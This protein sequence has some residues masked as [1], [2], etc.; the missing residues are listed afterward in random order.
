VVAAC[1]GD[2]AF[3]AAASA[4]TVP[5]YNEYLRA[6]PTGAH[7]R[8]ARARVDLLI[9]SADW[10]RAREVG[11]AES[12]QQYLARHSS[13]VHTQAA[14]VALAALNLASVAPVTAPLPEG[15]A[16]PLKVALGS[17]PAVAVTPGD[18]AGPAPAA[19]ATAPDAG[20][21]AVETDGFRVQLGAFATGSAAARAAWERLAASHPFLDGR[22]PL[23]A[24]ALS[25]DGVQIHRLQ[26]AGLTRE[27]ADALC[28]ALS[29]SGDACVIEPPA[30][31][32]PR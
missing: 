25:R 27:S 10:R 13:G 28:A 23:I 2:R 21:A 9:D 3:D 12:Y 1:G 24:A 29:A 17:G 11:T 18:A 31:R 30:G 7:A 20:P 14:L 16:A 6:H 15:T 8:E 32:R 4:D 19:A 22:H 5:A 26:V